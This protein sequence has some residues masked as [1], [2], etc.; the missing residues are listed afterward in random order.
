[1]VKDQLIRWILLLAKIRN[2]SAPGTKL[3]LLVVGQLLFGC[4]GDQKADLTIAV[5][6]NMQFAMEELVE[7]FNQQS[8]MHCV[9]VVSS[10]GKLTAQILNGAPF[11]VFVSADLQYPEKLYQAGLTTTPPQIYGN[12][13]LVLWTT[14]QQKPLS[15]EIL[16]HPQINHIA[17][18]NP[19]TAPFGKAAQQALGHYGLID[20]VKTKLVYAESISQVNQFV[21]SGV[22]EVGFTSMSVV[23]SSAFRD[24]GNWIEIKQD[25]YTLLNQAAVIIKN[26][27]SDK[28]QQFLQFL[29]SFEGENILDRYGLK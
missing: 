22:A 8:G 1:M 15:L 28:S 2:R 16:N 25:S 9:T 11:D 27:N 12:G 13:K 14:L 6:A 23:L 18:P 5:S 24:R 17:I 20:S 3:T 21:F 7:N 4:T 29:F 26:H 19:N 10:S